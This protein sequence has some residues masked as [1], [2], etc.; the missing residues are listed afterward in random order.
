MKKYVWFALLCMMVVFV[1]SCG[2]K[3]ESSKPA[4]KSKRDTLARVGNDVITLKEFNQKI[5]LLPD[6]IKGVIEENKA[7]FLDSLIVEALLYKEGVKKDLDNDREVRELLE[8]A[9]KKIVISRYI[10]DEIEDKSDVS[11]REIKSYY[12]ENRDDFMTPEVFRASHIL[13]DTMDE[14]VE[15]GDKLNAGAIFEEMA[16]RY[17]KDTTAK[18]GGDVGYFS[19]GQMVPEFEDACFVLKV[20]DVSG[21]V[22]TQFGYHIITLTEKKEPELMDFSEVEEKIEDVLISQKRRNLFDVLVEDLKAD[23]DININIDLLEAEE[24]KENE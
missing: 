17:S 9:K 2:Q 13:V 4:V 22:K 19:A 1:S 21:P 12:R 11:D 18:R 14:A 3:E 23:V 7:A 24:K 10:K 5:D 15:I 8:E 20:N 6:D 16:K